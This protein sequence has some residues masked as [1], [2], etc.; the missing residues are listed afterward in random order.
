MQALANSAF[1]Y[2]SGHL[3]LNN[4]AERWGGAERQNRE[5]LGKARLRQEIACASDFGVGEKAMN[6]K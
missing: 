6:K 5:L 3:R 1:H 2:A 4:G